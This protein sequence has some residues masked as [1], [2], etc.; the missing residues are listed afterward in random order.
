MYTVYSEGPAF[1]CSAIL[2]VFIRPPFLHCE[3]CSTCVHMFIL[4]DKLHF[5]HLPSSPVNLHCREKKKY[6]YNPTEKGS[7]TFRLQGEGQRFAVSRADKSV[8][9]AF[10][11]ADALHVEGWRSD[12]CS[13]ASVVNADSS[14]VKKPCNEILTIYFIYIFHS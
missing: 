12:S 5:W 4:Y 7:L 6:C 10:Q 3:L 1:E 11:L 13:L 9:A 14:N 8:R 2:W